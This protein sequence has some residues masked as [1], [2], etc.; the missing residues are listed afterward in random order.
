ME[1]EPNFVTHERVIAPPADVVRGDELDGCIAMIASADPGWDW[2]FT[3]R[4][5]GLVTAF[6]G[7]NS[8]TCR[9]ARLE[10]SCRPIGVGDERFRRWL[11]APTLELDAA[12]RLVRPLS[13][14][15]PLA[16]TPRCAR[17][18]PEAPDV[19][20]LILAAGR[21]SRMPA[22]TRSGPKCL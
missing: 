13:G 10:L 6:G 14:A 12:N 21:G 11:A 18:S 20:G 19:Q 15:P 7:A 5:A 3:H 9:C 16:A 17:R 8:A 4:I 22:L 2:I 1:D